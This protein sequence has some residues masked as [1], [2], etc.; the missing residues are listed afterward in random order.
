VQYDFTSN[1]YDYQD[2]SFYGQ[3]RTFRL[4]IRHAW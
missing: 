3:P 1:Y 4:G 2:P